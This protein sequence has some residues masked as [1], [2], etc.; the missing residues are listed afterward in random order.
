MNKSKYKRHILL[1]SMKTTF[2]SLARA[3]DKQECGVFLR[4]WTMRNFAQPKP[5]V[6]VFHKLG[7]PLVRWRI[8]GI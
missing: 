3:D 5:D 1:Y 6:T 2:S 4:S 7:H 8:A